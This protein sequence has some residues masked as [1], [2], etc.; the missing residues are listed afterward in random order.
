MISNRTSHW[1]TNSKIYWVWKWIKSRCNDKNNQAYNRYWWRW[2]NVSKSW[3]KFENFYKDMSEWYSEWLSI[4]RRKNH[5][6]YS[7]SNCLWVTAQKQAR[8]RRSNIIFTYNGKTQ[9]LTQ[10]CLDLWLKYAKVRDRI[11]RY[12]WKIEKALELI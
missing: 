12:N 4:E 10:W 6:W 5:L 2:I 1:L 7:K 8:N 11:K 3:E 9:C